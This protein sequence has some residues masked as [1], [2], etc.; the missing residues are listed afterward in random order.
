MRRVRMTHP[1][2]PDQE[3]HVPEKAVSG[4]QNIGWQTDEDVERAAAAN[5]AES[6]AA[7]PATGTPAATPRRITS[8][9]GKDKE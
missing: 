8:P 7:T 9:S 5:S 3:I 4:H 2:L 1:N 6:A